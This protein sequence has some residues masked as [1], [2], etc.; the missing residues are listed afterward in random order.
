MHN[1]CIF[2]LNIIPDV[3]LRGNLKNCLLTIYIASLYFLLCCSY[4]SQYDLIVLVHFERRK[5]VLS[6]LCHLC[7]S[8]CYFPEDHKFNVFICFFVQ[9]WLLFIPL[10]RLAY[11]AEFMI[12]S[13]YNVSGVGRGLLGYNVSGVG[14][15]LIGYYVS[16][17][18]RGLI[19]YNMSGV[20]SDL[21][22]CMSSAF[23]WRNWGSPEKAVGIVLFTS[24]FTPGKFR[25]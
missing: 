16:G 5:R 12:D 13:W 17:L 15:G 19:G 21:I 14:R 2:S 7:C 23:V 18:R 22:G 8:F 11:S 4:N 25:R 1:Y 9:F 3:V 20:G 24:R 10:R 6:W